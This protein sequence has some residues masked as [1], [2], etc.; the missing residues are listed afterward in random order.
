M[1]ATK[2]CAVRGEGRRPLRFLLR[3]VMLRIELRS[4]PEGTCVISRYLEPP[5]RYVFTHSI[6]HDS[7][8]QQRVSKL[9]KLDMK[10]DSLLDLARGIATTLLWM[11]RII[12][13]SLHVAPEPGLTSG[14]K[15]NS[16]TLR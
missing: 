15:Y 11:A 9:T 6:R 4:D 8:D 13:G 2:S 12:L 7:L 16:Q 10:G 3:R 14:T 5:E 1:G